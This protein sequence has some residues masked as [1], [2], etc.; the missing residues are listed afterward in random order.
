MSD[1][2]K[3]LSEAFDP[4]D[5][6]FRAG[7][8]NQDK[9]KALALAYITSR[10]VMDRLDTVVGP[11]GWQDQYQ[12]GPHGGVLCGISVKVDGEW[13]TKW[14]G[15]DNTQ[16]EAV[17]G[18]L[19]DAFK[20][21]AVKWGIGR[22]LYGLPAVWVTATQRGK[23]I[24]IDENEARQKL[25]GSTPKPAPKKSTPPTPASGRPYSPGVLREKIA[26]FVNVCE[27][28]N[29]YY[30]AETGDPFPIKLHPFGDKTANLLAAK[31]EG[32]FKGRVDDPKAAYKASLG[33]LFFGVDS[34][35]DLTAP[36]AAAMFKVM[37]NGKAEELSWDSEVLD[38][39]KDEL[40]AT[41]QEAM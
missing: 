35:N 5:V 30:D 22:Y 6:E 36:E 17:K 29:L 32:V 39:A 20:R 25:F 7:A 41:Y 10:A 9:S 11:E 31:W 27:A 37:F 23:S 18:G 1:L 26:A 40:L 14:D 28:K 13:I 15:A 24:S 12:P 2:I 38:V 4:A 8:T 33:F 19:S 34:A 16:V 21:A 3:R